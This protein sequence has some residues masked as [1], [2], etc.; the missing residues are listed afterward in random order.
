MVDRS[1]TGINNVL[2]F[3]MTKNLEYRH[4]HVLVLCATPFKIASSIQSRCQLAE[5]CL[6]NASVA[7]AVILQPASEDLVKHTLS[8]L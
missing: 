1:E 4:S 8:V 7:Y 3:E 5:L 2:P 6:R